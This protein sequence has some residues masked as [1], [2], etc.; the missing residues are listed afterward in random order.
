MNYCNIRISGSIKPEYIDDIA[1]MVLRNTWNISDDKRIITTLPK[2]IFDN[3]K[4]ISD[5]SLLFKD[6]Q[7]GKKYLPKF[8]GETLT[9]QF[10]K[11]AKKKN[12]LSDFSDIINTFQDYNFDMVITDDNHTRLYSTRIF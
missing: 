1:D 9:L 4:L 7:R 8:D 6:W 2:Q 10:I 11:K 3:C 12:M 5:S